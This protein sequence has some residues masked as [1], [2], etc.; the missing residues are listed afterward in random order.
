MASKPKSGLYIKRHERP[1]RQAQWTPRSNEGA[2]SEGYVSDVLVES[3]G[4]GN[5]SN[6]RGTNWPRNFETEEPASENPSSSEAYSSRAQ[7]YVVETQSIKDLTGAK[8]IAVPDIQPLH[9]ESEY[10]TNDKRIYGQPS[11]TLYEQSIPS[12][13]LSPRP[14]TEG[15]YHGHPAN[16]VSK[17]AGT[18]KAKPGKDRTS[19]IAT[20]RLYP[21]K[22]K[23]SHIATVR[24]IPNS[25]VRSVKG[26]HLGYN[27]TVRGHNT[28]HIVKQVKQS[29]LPSWDTTD[30]TMGFRRTTALPDRKEYCFT[31]FAI[32]LDK[33][34]RECYTP[35]EIISG[36]IILE[37]NTNVEIRFVEL[38]ILGLATVHVGKH[39]PNHA[40]N[41]QEVII[42]KR[43]YIMGTP[44]G[45]W[46]SVITEGK[47]VSK[48]RFNLPKDIP[49]SIRYEN[50]EHGLS[51]EIGYQVKARI[52]DELGSASA[53]STH[54]LNTLVK[55]LMSRKHPFFVR[56]PFDINAIPSALTPVNYR[57]FVNLNCLPVPSDSAMLTLSLDRSVFLA[58]DVI[59]V[60]LS[61]SQGTARKIK[62]LTCQLQQ[63]MTSSLK[64]KS[65][66]TLVQIDEHEPE[67]GMIQPNV[68][69]T[70]SFDFMIPTQNQ[71]IPTY[72]QGCK[73]L[74]VSY[75]VMMYVTFNACADRL[76]LEA[77][78]AIGPCTDP[79]NLD[80]TNSVPIFNRPIRFP[81]F[82]KENNDKLQNGMIHTG[83]T[84]GN[85]VKSEHKQ[86]SRTFLLCC[87]EEA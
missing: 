67:V 15:T 61:T 73:L 40:K 77:P 63:R 41:A 30:G 55:V 68:R 60:K 13:F 5:I 52:C 47:Y 6:E 36:R 3:Y 78:I 12:S 82:S 62:H 29:R 39:D 74:K 1:R 56:R 45:R 44:D 4:E 86:S 70:V 38:L 64:P 22:K 59:R 2:D 83:T 42:N 75:Y 26:Y 87:V 31:Q 7:K 35:G 48:F 27:V 54:S 66:Y 21:R 79:Q 16:V 18:L 23:P 10:K 24:A 17:P 58:G 9:L 43:S 14:R 84:R 65:T 71:F 80:K 69:N 25:G 85:Q 57:D 51:F 20:V 33:P 49:T 32:E 8:Y 50:Q 34:E 28:G 46:N 37:V 76:I 19:H 81:H 53:R 72:L 11:G